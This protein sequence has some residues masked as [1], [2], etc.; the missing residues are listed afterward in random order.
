ML[1]R[2]RVEASSRTNG[3]VGACRVAA[4]ASCPEDGIKPAK[5]A[6]V[7]TPEIGYVARLG[8]AGGCRARTTAAAGAR[9]VG[10]GRATSRPR[11]LRAPSRGRPSVQASPRSPIRRTHRNRASPSRSPADPFRDVYRLVLH[12]HDGY[13]QRTARAAG[14]PA[15]ARG[16]PRRRRRLLDR[17]RPGRSRA[18][19][20]D[21]SSPPACCVEGASMTLPRPGGARGRGGHRGAAV[22]RRQDARHPILTLPS[23][24]RPEVEA[25]ESLRALGL[26]SSCSRCA[27]ARAR[28]RSGPRRA[29]WR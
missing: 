23:G 1:R 11:T 26:D 9:G 10:A 28:R 21:A 14:R 18:S 22:R 19:S 2:L 25:I 29:A 3:V 20:C 12:E 7:D 8:A 5:T 27:S 6:F 16:A 13:F 4:L 15:G 24:A 17:P